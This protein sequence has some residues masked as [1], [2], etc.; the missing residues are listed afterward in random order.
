MSRENIKEKCFNKAWYRLVI[1]PII[2]MGLIVSNSAHQKPHYSNQDHYLAK[3]SET[4][5]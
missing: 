2:S 1:K 3:A 5:T 4:H